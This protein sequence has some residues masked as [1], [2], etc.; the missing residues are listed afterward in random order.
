MQ[1][2]LQGLK[3]LIIVASP[4]DLLRELRVVGLFPLSFAKAL[5][6]DIKQLEC[7]E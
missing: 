1:A 3:Y 6:V 2:L 4:S 7:L 5:I